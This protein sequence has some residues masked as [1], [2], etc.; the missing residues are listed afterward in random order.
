MAAG[1]SLKSLVG[2]RRR[3]DEE[4]EDEEGPVMVDDSQS[5]ATMLSDM[6]EDD[7]DASSL[8]APSAADAGVDS[9]QQKAEAAS[10]GAKAAGKK[11]RKG[12]KNAKRS[13]KEPAPDSSSQPQVNSFKA[14]AD[15]EAMMNGLKIGDQA[16]QEVAEFDSLDRNGPS[17]TDQGE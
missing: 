14:A 17:A 10:N 13:G 15:T 4:G 7:A 9:E 8:G 1:R 6:E 12:K 5:E 2:R 11:A 16:S 3:V